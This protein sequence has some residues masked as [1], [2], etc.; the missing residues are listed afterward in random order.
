MHA[1]DFFGGA[2]GGGG[3]FVVPVSFVGSPRASWGFWPIFTPIRSFLSLEIR[4]S[5]LGVE[6]VE[7]DFDVGYI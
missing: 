3:K 2:G 5:P 4:S 7:V 6:I 1:W